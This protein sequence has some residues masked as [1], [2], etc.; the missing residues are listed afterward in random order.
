[1]SFRPMVA[2]NRRIRVT[3]LRPAANE[4]AIAVRDHAS[5]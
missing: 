1:M 2:R 4:W 5:A 3:R